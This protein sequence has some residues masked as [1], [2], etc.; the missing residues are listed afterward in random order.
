MGKTQQVGRLVLVKLMVASL[1]IRSLIILDFPGFQNRIK[2]SSLYEMRT[3]R[4]VYGEQT[5]LFIIDSIPHCP[6][7]RRIC[8][9]K[10]NQEMWLHCLIEQNWSIYH[11]KYSTLS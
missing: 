5:G 4:S 2:Y 11:R 10:Q 7:G 8:Q 1:S 6:S 9:N 3:C